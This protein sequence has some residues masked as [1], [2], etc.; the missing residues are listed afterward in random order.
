MEGARHEYGKREMRK[1][2]EQK[3]KHKKVKN[4]LFL[5]Q[6]DQALK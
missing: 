1:R 4:C 2:K 6:M 3:L 5:K